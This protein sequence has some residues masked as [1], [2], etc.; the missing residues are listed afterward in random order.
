MFEYAIEKG[1]GRDGFEEEVHNGCGRLRLLLWMLAHDADT[2]DCA[3]N[4]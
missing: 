3:K 2:T 4:N 1:G